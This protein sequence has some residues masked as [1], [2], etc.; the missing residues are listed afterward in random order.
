MTNTKTV[1]ATVSGNNL[2]GF[3]GVFVTVRGETFLAAKCATQGD[4]LALVPRIE[5]MAWT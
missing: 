2:F 4:A 3:W 1:R 5:A